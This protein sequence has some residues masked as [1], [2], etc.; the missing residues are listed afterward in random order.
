MNARTNSIPQNLAELVRKHI[1][2]SLLCDFLKAHK[3]PVARSWDEIF[4]KN[5]N[6]QVFFLDLLRDVVCFGNKSIFAFDANEHLI[7]ELEGLKVSSMSIE[8][9]L[10]FGSE[11]YALIDKRNDGRFYSYTFCRTR[12]AGETHVLSGNDL[13]PE[14]KRK[15]WTPDSVVRIKTNVRVTVFDS[16]IYD[17]HNDIL[18]VIIDNKKYTFEESVY[19][20]QASFI[21]ELRGVCPS[22]SKLSMIDFYPAIEGIYQQ[23]NEGVI[24]RLEFE[25]NTGV[26]RDE[27]LKP[28]QLDLR[29]EGYHIQGKAAIGGGIRPFKIGV[30]WLPS[31]ATKTVSQVEFEILGTRKQLHR[32]GGM[33][34][35]VL[36]SQGSFNELAFALH[37]IAL[38]V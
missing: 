20:L 38:Y 34:C 23:P 1:S 18:Y 21:T 6:E 11:N 28:G 8:T 13:I 5:S 2:H 24:H 29:N 26:V 31:A 19:E 25:C 22:F 12:M 32:Q 17:S 37:R 3:K 33:H 4:A 27:K 9:A 7:A 36:S 16:V 15:L 14:T 10:S 35:A 30:T